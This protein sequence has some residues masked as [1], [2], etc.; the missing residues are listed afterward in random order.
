MTKTEYKNYKDYYVY[1]H[2]IE[3]S[4]TPFYVGSG[5]KGRK[6]IKSGRNQRWNLQVENKKWYSLVIENGLS[7]REALDRENFYIEKYREFIVNKI[8]KVSHIRDLDVEWLSKRYRYD[9]TSP[10]CLVYNENTCHNKEGSVAGNINNAG[11]YEVTNKRDSCSGGYTIGV[12]RV[13]MVLHGANITDLYVDHKNG[14]KTDNR[15]SN[16]RVV[17]PSENQKNRKGSSTTKFLGVRRSKSGYVVSNEKIKKV[18]G[19]RKHGED[20][21]F[22][23]AIWYRIYI[24]DDEVVKDRL[25]NNNIDLS[26]IKN[27]TDK[28]KLDKIYDNKS[29]SNNSGFTGVSE[30]EKSHRFITQIPLPGGDK[31]RKSFSYGKTKNVSRAEAWLSACEYYNKRMLELYNTYICQIIPEVRINE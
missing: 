27:L 12:H 6:D 20:I 5:R 3:G 25:M 2:F 1:L 10:S 8:A 16:L 18:I 7:K 11:Y 9:E 19:I 4:E 28:E 29:G 21:A 17:S 22:A 13:I 24:E 30:R 26:R 31:E 15:I 23:L 14:V